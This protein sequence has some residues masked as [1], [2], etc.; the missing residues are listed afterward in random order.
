M[1]FNTIARYFLLTSMLISSFPSR[2]AW[3][4]PGWS[5]PNS[6]GWWSTI[7]MPSSWSR[8]PDNYLGVLAALGAV[9]LA[10]AAGYGYYNY[11]TYQAERM[12]VLRELYT[13]LTGL[14]EY[15]LNPL[16]PDKQEVWTQWVNYPE[17]AFNQG[18]TDIESNLGVFGVRRGF[19]W[20]H[21]PAMSRNARIVDSFKNQILYQKGLEE[22]AEKAGRP[23]PLP[24]QAFKHAIKELTLLI[25][26]YLS[27]AEERFLIELIARGE[28]ES[29]ATR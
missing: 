16:S 26:S 22:A 29:V 20:G 28:Q 6:A 24:G 13:Q 15:A 5:Q 17:Y 27:K 18:I 12:V 2:T 14:L 19:F 7:Q 9:S 3:H 8:S 23:K 4:E 25:G 1:Y 21:S 11:A 10:G